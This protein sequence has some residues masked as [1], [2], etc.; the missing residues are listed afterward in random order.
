MVPAW[1]LGVEGGQV[2]AT[3]FSC[4]TQ[5]WYLQWLIAM[6][7]NEDKSWKTNGLRQRRLWRF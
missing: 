1:G 6:V 4:A 7:R 3:I 2:C 5:V